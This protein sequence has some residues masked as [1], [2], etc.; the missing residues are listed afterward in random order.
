MVDTSLRQHLAAYR[1]R[2]PDEADVVDQFVQLLDD[3]TDPFV[4]ERVEGHFTG[5]AWVVSADGS[6]TLLTHHRKL[7]RWL[8]L[9]GH[10]D[11]ERDLAQVA[12]RE[13][14]EESGLAGLWLADAA[15]FDLDRHWIPARGEVAGHWHYDARYVV[16][17]GADET[18]KVSEE[19]LALAWRL[20][21]ELLAE[22][23]LDPSMRR[24]AEKWMARGV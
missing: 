7:Q 14:E 5:S 17:A 6:R 23:E 20:I 1:A 13:A 22:P 24:M 3:A 19:S 12:L 18:F 2:F 11:G 10:A 21:A 8:Q 15:L 4:R 16:V 9:G